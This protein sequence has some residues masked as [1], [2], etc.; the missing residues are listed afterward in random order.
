[1]DLLIKEILGHLQAI[2]C[3]CNISHTGGCLSVIISETE[4]FGQCDVTM[5]IFC[6]VIAKEA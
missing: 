4:K 3:Q 6:I 5:S 2:V 1:M